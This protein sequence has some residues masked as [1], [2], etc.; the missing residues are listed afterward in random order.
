MFVIT[1]QS[2]VLFVLATLATL[3]VYLLRGTGAALIIALC[4]ALGTTALSLPLW[5]GHGRRYDTLV[6]QLDAAPQTV[7][8]TFRNFQPVM[9]DRLALEAA[10]H[11][12]FRAS[13]SW[14][15]VKVQTVPTQGDLRFSLLTSAETTVLNFKGD[16]G[17]GY[18]IIVPTSDLEHI[19]TALP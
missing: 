14:W 10:I 13:Q 6:R 3:V 18:R 4:A 9:V 15:R 7:T 11:T 19:L 17:P 16:E 12:A 8:F 2:A 1:K 5:A